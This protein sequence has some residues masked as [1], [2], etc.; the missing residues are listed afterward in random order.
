MGICVRVCGLALGANMPRSCAVCFANRCVAL[1]K[2]WLVN[3][4]NAQK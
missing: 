2:K 3:R 1:V 4:Q